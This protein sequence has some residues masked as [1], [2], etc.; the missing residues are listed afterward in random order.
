MKILKIILAI[1]CIL[2]IFFGIVY[3]LVALPFSSP[4]FDILAWAAIGVAFVIALIL[5]RGK[6]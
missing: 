4:F 3:N 1:I 5:G 2:L 6:G